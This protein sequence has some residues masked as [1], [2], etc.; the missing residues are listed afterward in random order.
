MIEDGHVE[1]GAIVVND[2]IGITNQAIYLPNHFLAGAG[3]NGVIHHLFLASPLSGP[4]ERITLFDNVV[5]VDVL[6]PK[7]PGIYFMWSSLYI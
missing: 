6:V 1:L 2:G 5:R 3:M 7:A 4:T